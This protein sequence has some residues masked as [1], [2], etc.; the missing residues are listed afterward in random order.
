MNVDDNECGAVAPDVQDGDG[1]PPGTEEA[2]DEPFVEEDEGDGS[3]AL[4]GAAAGT[5]VVDEE[6]EEAHA[7]QR[8]LDDVH[9][10][11]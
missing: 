6:Y 4:S 11:T 9:Q 5:D 10:T 1:A 7:S 8:S 2:M 3:P